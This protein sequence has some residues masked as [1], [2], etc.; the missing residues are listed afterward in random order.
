MTEKQWC[1]GNPEYAWEAVPV[2]L[3]P[4]HSLNKCDVILKVHLHELRLQCDTILAYLSRNA[5]SVHSVFTR[6]NLIN[7]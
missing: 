1:E 3:L 7:N 4:F 2:I 5:S 6:L